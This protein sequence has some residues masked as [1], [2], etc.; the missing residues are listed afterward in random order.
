MGLKE[1]SLTSLVKR[2]PLTSSEAD[3]LLHQMLGALD[4]L[5][6]KGIVHRDVKPAN[7]LYTTQQ[8]GQH[9]FYLGDFGLCNTVNHA[10]SIVGTDRYIAPEIFEEVYQTDKVDVWSLFVTMQSVLPVNKF[11]R[12]L[13]KAKG[14]GQ[15]KQAVLDAA[16]SN[17]VLG[18]REMAIVNPA[19]RASAAQMLVKR[20]NGQG[21]STPRH[22][23]PALTSSHIFN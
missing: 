19:Q 17:D 1:G 12:N 21:L 18:I 5:A 11:T 8:D 2:K 7:I 6:S 4:Y 14:Y 3:L 9:R 20:Y 13:N 15:I 16:E 23:V 22:Q 10:N